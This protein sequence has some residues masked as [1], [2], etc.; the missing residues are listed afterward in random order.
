MT[1]VVPFQ[2]FNCDDHLIKTSCKADRAFLFGLFLR[3]F[4][5]GLDLRAVCDLSA[6]RFGFQDALFIRDKATGHQS[7]IIVVPLARLA[8][9][10]LRK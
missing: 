7:R 2:L 6:R 4:T 8:L 10:Y 5:A 3:V 9:E 1:F